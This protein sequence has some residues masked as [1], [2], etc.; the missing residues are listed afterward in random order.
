MKSTLAA[1][2]LIVFTPSMFPYGSLIPHGDGNPNANAYVGQA[3]STYDSQANPARTNGTVSYNPMAPLPS[4]APPAP[5]GSA[6]PG[7]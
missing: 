5:S 3:G 4:V 1:L 6:M 7:R 2:S